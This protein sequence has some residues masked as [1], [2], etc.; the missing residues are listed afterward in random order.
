MK[1]SVK[2]RAVCHKEK[3]TVHFQNPFTNKI[4][5]LKPLTLDVTQSTL[6]QLRVS[7]QQGPAAP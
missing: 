7:V 4:F 1:S 5:A 2:E 3:G 6:V